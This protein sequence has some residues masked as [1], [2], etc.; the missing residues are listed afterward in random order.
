MLS[1]RSA[2]ILCT[3]ISATGTGQTLSKSGHLLQHLGQEF[4]LDKLQRLLSKDGDGRTFFER[5]LTIREKV[6][7]TEHPQTIEAHN[8]PAFVTRAQGNLVA[9]QGHY[10]RALSISKKLRGLEH[11]VT[12]TDISNLACVI[13]D[14]GH[15]NDAEPLVCRAIAIGEKVLGA[16]HALTQRFRSQCARLFLD[17][18]RPAEALAFAEG[19]LAVHA[20]TNGPDHAWTKDP[21]RVTVDALASLGRAE[22][23]AALRA[24][25]GIELPGVPGN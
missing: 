17:T 21:A 3:S 14:A 4:S 1:S 19:A 20:E 13:R 24:R 23:A 9:A 18:G 5:A 10:E 15:P 8:N 16:G 6:R 12:A 25:F 2:S 7:G 22:A 11:P